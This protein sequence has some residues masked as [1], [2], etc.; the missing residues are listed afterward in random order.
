[1]Q[2]KFVNKYF[3]WKRKLLS[4]QDSYKGDEGKGKAGKA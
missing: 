3:A 2:L 1:M 4:P